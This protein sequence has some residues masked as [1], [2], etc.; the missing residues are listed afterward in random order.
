MRRS[1]RLESRSTQSGEKQAAPNGAAPAETPALEAVSPGKLSFWL[2]RNEHSDLQQDVLPSDHAATES[3]AV[4]PPIPSAT[5]LPTLPRLPLPPEAGPALSRIFRD[6]RLGEQPPELSG[7]LTRL[8][9]ASNAER[10][11]ISALHRATTRITSSIR[12]RGLGP[13]AIQTHSPPRARGAE[14]DGQAFTRCS[15]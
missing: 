1:K 12:H 7:M 13:R 14:R 5:P 10:G 8:A 4:I 6:V 11:I 9:A 15:I 3:G 2:V